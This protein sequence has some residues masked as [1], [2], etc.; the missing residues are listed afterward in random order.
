MNASLISGYQ[1][2]HSYVHPNE[3][4]LYRKTPSETYE[5][6]IK[7]DKWLTLIQNLVKEND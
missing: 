1:R 4:V 5:I 2:F 7:G 6:K 3:C